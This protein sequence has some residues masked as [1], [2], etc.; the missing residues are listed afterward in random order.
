MGKLL[1]TAGLVAWVGFVCYSRIYFGCHSLPQI[2]AGLTL[3]TTDGSLWYLV[4]LRWFVP[5]YLEKVVK[6]S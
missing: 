4:Y 3:G 6:N 2:V 5:R 1:V